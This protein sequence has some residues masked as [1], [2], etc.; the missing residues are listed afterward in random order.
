MGKR[1]TIQRLFFQLVLS[2]T[3]GSEHTRDEHGIPQN[4]LET[5]VGM[6]LSCSPGIAN[7]NF[8]DINGLT[9]ASSLTGGDSCAASL[10]EYGVPWKFVLVTGRDNRV[11]LVDI[12]A[13]ISMNGVA[14]RAQPP[15]TWIS[16]ADKSIWV[17]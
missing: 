5:P 11:D 2:S 7:Y 4:C 6:S 3:S 10:K 9:P 14:R 17:S 12:F 15:S 1:Q 16:V 13:P 8:I